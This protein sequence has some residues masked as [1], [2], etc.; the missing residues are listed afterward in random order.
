MTR[1]EMIQEILDYPYTDFTRADF[2]HL[3]INK[4]RRI[5]RI[6]STSPRDG[7]CTTCA[8]I[9]GLWVQEFRGG[10]WKPVSS[11]VFTIGA[12]NAAMDAYLRDN[13]D[14]YEHSTSRPSGVRP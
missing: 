13:P 10:S 12:L 3:D 5:H 7:A 11:M 2:E 8:D 9:K 14:C 1:E 6:S 4:L